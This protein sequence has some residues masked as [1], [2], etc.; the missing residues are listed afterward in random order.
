VLRR[1]TNLYE[2]TVEGTTLIGQ[3]QYSAKVDLLAEINR[4]NKV[5]SNNLKYFRPERS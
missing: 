4:A 1:N 2:S 3:A 5:V